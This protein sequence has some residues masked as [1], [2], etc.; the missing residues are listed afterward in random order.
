MIGRLAVYGPGAARL[1][2]EF[3]TVTA[4][5]VEAERDRKPLQPFGRRGQE[6]TFAQLEQALSDARPAPDQVIER[7]RRYAAK[8]AEDLE[9]ELRQRK[10]ERLE[11]VERDLAQRGADEA[12]QLAELLQQQRKRIARARDEKDPRQQEFKFP[13]D[14]E[15]KQFEAD[16][17]HWAQRLESID[18]ELE[19]EPERV[20]ESYR[21][22]AHRLE[23]VGLLYLWPRTG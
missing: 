14:E 17:R 21:P 10:D 4:P 13:N 22:K 16:R 5:W 15:R 20:R 11:A 12:R 7:V 23:A 1:H 18:R 9:P 19:T 3:V 6:T 2:E 8:D